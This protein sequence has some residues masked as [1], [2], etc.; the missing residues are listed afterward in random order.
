M[1]LAAGGDAQLLVE[2]GAVILACGLLARFA[3]W[4]GRYRCELSGHAT[5]RDTWG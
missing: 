3:R 4:L 1:I 5:F 2:L